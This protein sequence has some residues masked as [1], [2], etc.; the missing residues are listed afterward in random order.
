M[1]CFPNGMVRGKTMTHN[2][3]VNLYHSVFRSR[4]EE[5][6]EALIRSFFGMQQENR[7]TPYD[8]DVMEWYMHDPMFVEKE[9][10]AYIRDMECLDIDLEYLSLYRK[11]MNASAVKTEEDRL[12]YVDELLTYTTLSFFLTIYSYAFD[13][14]EK[15]TK[16][17]V[18][19]MFNIL[20]IQGK[21][22]TIAVHSISEILEMITLPKNIIDLAAD[23]FWTAWTFMIG[24]ELFHLTVNE[25]LL[26]IQEEHNADA[27]GYQ[28]L[29]HMMREQK[30]ENIPENIKVFYEYLYLSPVMLFTF[31][32]LLDEYRSLSGINVNYEDHPAP[33]KR[34]S[35]ILELADTA[36]PDD[37]DTEQGNELLNIFLDAVE[38]LKSMV[39]QRKLNE[40]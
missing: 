25:N 32:E 28:V 8:M 23:T 27:Y 14:S 40:T 33:E 9:I 4:E 26:A 3:L 29:L 22:H 11:Q 15:N 2:K 12:V 39:Y 36:V 19:N 35:H 37:F 6:D 34:K 30:K 7:N 21:G 38:L 24:H 16:R 31:F 18:N 10:I 1:F 13:S 5:R 20:E 17:C